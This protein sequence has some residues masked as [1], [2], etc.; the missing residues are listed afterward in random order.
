[1]TPAILVQINAIA[2][3]CVTT[4]MSRPELLAVHQALADAWEAVDRHLRRPAAD[5]MNGGAA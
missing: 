5:T 4:E 2:R 3:V 1:M